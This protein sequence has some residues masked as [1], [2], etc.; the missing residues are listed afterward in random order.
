[1]FSLMKYRLGL[2]S[3]QICDGLSAVSFGKTR[4]TSPEAIRSADEFR[5]SAAD[6]HVIH[7]LWSQVSDPQG[8]ETGHYDLY[9]APAR[10]AVGPPSAARPAVDPPS[11]K[12]R[13]AV[14]GRFNGLTVNSDYDPL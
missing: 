14:T 6:E 5:R 11:K 10:P 12:T 1:M 4:G 8:N 7:I 2:T 3:A 9:Q 13:P